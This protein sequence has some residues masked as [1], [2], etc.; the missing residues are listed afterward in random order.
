MSGNAI[1]MN[2]TNR[3]GCPERSA[4]PATTR[5]ADAPISVPFPPRH[6]PSASDHHR[7]IKCS[8]PPNA[9]AMDLISGIMVATKGMLSTKAERIAE[10]HSMA[11][12][13]EVRSPWVKDVK[14]K[15]EKEL[16]KPGGENVYP[17]EVEKVIL[18]HPEVADV[19]V[20]GVR[21]PEW[22]EAIKAVC[23]L[24]VGSSLTE[25]GLIDFVASRI[26]RYKKPKYVAFVSALPKAQDG[27][28]DREKVKAEHGK[29]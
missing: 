3:M 29:A 23:V 25:Q 14:R 20:I 17:A 15:A 18:E 13:V 4:N 11:M 22:G 19:S 10:P 21:D 6:A 2:G 24:K 5:F 26:A 8:V 1:S 27:S 16:I 12:V 7:G 9:G 28:L